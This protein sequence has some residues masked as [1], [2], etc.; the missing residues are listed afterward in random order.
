MNATP[1]LTDKELL[2]SIS[3]CVFDL[4]TTGGNHDVDQII[5][6][7]LVRV[8]NQKIIA[9][10]HLMVKPE[11]E[12]PIFIQ[13]LTSISPSDM[14][15]AKKI[16]E[17]IDEILEFMGD[18][19]LVAHNVSFDVPFF[20]SVLRRLGRPQLQNKSLCTV[21]MTK[22]L[23]PDLLNSNLNYMSKI[24][25]ID[26]AK[27]HRALDDTKAT[28]ELLLTYLD[29]FA[30]KGINK[31]NH[32]YY[33]RNRYELDRVNFE[34]KDGIEPILKKI[35]GI[36][37]PYLLTVKGENG[38]ILFTLPGKKIES[39]L[40]YINKN[41]SSSKWELATIRIF[42]SFLEAFVHFNSYFGK[43]DAVVKNEIM[44]FLW[45]AHFNCSPQNQILSED[46][47]EAPLPSPADH[48]DFVVLYHLIPEQFAI[49]PLLAMHPKSE[50]VF[51]YPGHK[52]KLVQYISSKSS[53]LAA[54]KVKKTFFPPMIIPFLNRYLEKAEQDPANADV[55]LF[56]KTL[57][58]KKEAEFYAT[59]EAFLKKNA[60]SSTYPRQYL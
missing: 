32:L 35:E 51:R 31:I 37:T 2:D 6:I 38:I 39:E 53:K 26:H 14:K 27:A 29:I 56:K 50:L 44:Q 23:I 48:G 36:K 57:P 16:E 43:I 60:Q 10:K 15:D 47:A 30:N 25:G 41:L 34:V 20:N 18:S 59:L 21:L 3:F 8:Q 19:I 11:I 13:R 28:A 46:K 58:L 9:E 45:K 54:N 55:F 22:Y 49:F 4:E 7:G 52:K 42:G 1:T 17:V 33:P 12:I 24:F 5:E 40:T